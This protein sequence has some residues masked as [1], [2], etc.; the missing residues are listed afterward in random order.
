M[1]TSLEPERVVVLEPTIL[2]EIRRPEP[3]RPEWGYFMPCAGVRYYSFQPRPTSRLRT[4]TVAQAS[5]E[6]PAVKLIDEKLF[7]L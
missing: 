3:P 2:P 5:P 4:P 1:V 6:R 7:V